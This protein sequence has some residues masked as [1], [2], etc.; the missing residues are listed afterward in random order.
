[1]I[2]ILGMV[3]AGV[4]DVVSWLASAV[5]LLCVLPLCILTWQGKAHPRP[6]TWAIWAAVGIVATL[7]MAVGGAPWSAWLLKGALSLGPVA[8][9]LIAAY[10]GEGVVADRVD[11][12]CLVVGS[13][14]TFAYGLLLTQGADA[15]EAGLLAVGTA[16][17][18]DAIGAVPTWLN[19]WR[20]PHD[21]LITTYA[22]AL[23]SVV[24]VLCILPVPWTW[25]S[26]AYLCFL[27]VQMAS[28]IGVLWVGRRRV[29]EPDQAARYGV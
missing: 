6:V 22:L 16:M 11:R 13:V 21:E 20:H 18:V 10:K 28:I 3:P 9:A 14:G 25:L 24:A 5:T 27:A 17:L 12:W 19:A 29:R 15:A 8:V 26:S 23:A 1:V 4:I 7:A 2:T